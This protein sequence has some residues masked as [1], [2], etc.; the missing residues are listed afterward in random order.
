MR[1]QCFPLAECVA[2]RI[3]CKLAGDASAALDLP[4]KVDAPIDRLALVAPPLGVEKVWAT[5]WDAG[6]VSQK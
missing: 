3:P 5:R 4:F 1:A 6:N 2:S